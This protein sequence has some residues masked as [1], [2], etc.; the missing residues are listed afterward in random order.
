ME[1]NIYIETDAHGPARRKK[2]K[3]IY[4]LEC[5]INDKPYTVHEVLELEN[6]TEN[7][8]SLT[9]L[10]TALKRMTKSSVI[11]VFMPCE[12]VLN[13]LNGLW[14]IQWQKNGWKNAAGRTVKNAELWQEVTELLSGHSYMV[15]N[16]K[17]SYGTWM[18]VELRKN[19]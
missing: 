4:L 9:L 1:V 2:A 16:E 14:N 3:G 12:H 10:A 15:C 7:Q 5:L 18:N 11:R 13:T 8:M 19:N 17:H 6:T